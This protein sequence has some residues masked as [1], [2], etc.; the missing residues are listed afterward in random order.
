MDPGRDVTLV[1]AP[2]NVLFADIESVVLA[3][4]VAQIAKN[5]TQLAA[6]LDDQATG[7]TSLT[8]PT[9]LGGTEHLQFSE[10]LFA[11]DSTLDRPRLVTRANLG[12][13]LGPGDPV[14][15]LRR[16]DRYV[17]DAYILGTRLTRAI[18]WK[19]QDG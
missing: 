4:A 8:S 5:P 14:L 19:L 15:V 11:A 6:G 12:D 1:Q 13:L 16:G 17:G 18:K 10:D 9:A 3:K 2:G 7:A